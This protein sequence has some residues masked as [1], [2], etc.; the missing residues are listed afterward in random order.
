MAGAAP[1]QLRLDPDT[2]RELASQG[3]ALLCLDVPAGTHIG[4]DHQVGEEPSP[5]LAWRPLL[6]ARPSAAPSAAL[7]RGS[8]AIGAAASGR[9]RSGPGHAPIAPPPAGLHLGP[10]L[11]GRQDAAARAA[12]CQLLPRR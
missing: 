1:Y 5:P 6:A 3:A 10:Q 2:A 12:L 11:Q 9:A 7:R 8:S 4:I